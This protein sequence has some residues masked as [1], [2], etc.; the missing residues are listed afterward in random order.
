M[1]VHVPET[2]LL[3]YKNYVESFPKVEAA[4]FHIA[5]ILDRDQRQRMIVE[6]KSGL[7]P[8]GS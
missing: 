5:T 7:P 6:I 2:A 1:K 4:L 8:V 3:K